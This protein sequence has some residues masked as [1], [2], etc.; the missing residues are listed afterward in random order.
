MGIIFGDRGRIMTPDALE[1]VLRN[2]RVVLPDGGCSIMLAES[3]FDETNTHKGNDRLC[4]GGYVFHKEKAEQ[5]A[6][7]WAELLT[8]WNLP[9]FHMVDCAHNIGVFAHLSPT[10]C[11]L[12]A[13][14]AIQIIKDT[15]ETG[16]AIT[17]LESEYLEVMPDMKFFGSAYD[18]LARDVI[19]GVSAWLE[20]TAFKGAMHY[21]FEEGTATERNAGYC[22]TQF[23][24]DPEI[25]KE[26]CYEGH[27]FVKKIRSPGVQAADILAWH[28]GQDCKRALRGDPIRKDFASLTEIPHRVFHYTP[29]KLREIAGI[30][31]SELAAA[32]LT[33]ELAKSLD[34]LARR[35]P[36]TLRN[37]LNL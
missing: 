3:Y 20:A 24:R 14:E 15:A 1:A 8:K 26:T 30:I 6:I 35:M 28:A 21:Y 2:I 18:S 37:K 27:S 23:M 9:Y 36:R 5:Q 4:I 19:S 16:V 29:E 32:G 33:Q 13:R 31:Q 10:E 25:R 34:E 12:A 22:I 11:D 17:V 7:R